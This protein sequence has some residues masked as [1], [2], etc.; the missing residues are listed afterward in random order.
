MKL[1]ILGCGN[2]GGTIGRNLQ[3]QS[4]E[5]QVVA[6]YDIDR[7]KAESLASEIKP[8]PAVCK[9]V[10][11]LLKNKEATLILEAASQEAVA[12]YGKKIL[13]SGKSL[14]IMSVGAFSDDLLLKE[15]REIS[16]K[17]KVKIYIPSGAVAGIDGLKSALV[18][19][20]TQVTLTTRK[21]PKNLD[22]DVKKETVLYVG[23]AREGIKKYPKNVN[24]A[25][26]LSLAGIGLDK[27]LLRII[28]DPKIEKNT[29]EILV[30]GAFGSFSVLMENMPSPDNPKTSYLAILSAMAMLKKFSEP[31]E[32]GT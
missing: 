5:M 19:G 30:K 21:N 27:T 1:A 12:L 7:K 23:P 9:D 15:M 3:K 22:V 28:A 20:V 29:H 2:I 25:A 4:R 26:T 11:E 13:E 31:I 10:D 6:V 16:E 8:R 24:V 32:I 18:G 14:M 17:R